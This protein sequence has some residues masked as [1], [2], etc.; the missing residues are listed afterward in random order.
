MKTKVAVLSLIIVV[1]VGAIAV[2]RPVKQTTPEQTTAQKPPEDTDDT[3]TR[4]PQSDTTAPPAA[5]P[6]AKQEE[7][8]KA[9]SPSARQLRG[10]PTSFANVEIVA[11]NLE[12]PWEI[13]FL[14]NGEMLLTERKGNLL[15]IGFDG[16]RIAIP[17]PDV[18][19]GG[20]GGLLGLT[21]HSEFA[22]N[23]LLYLYITTDRGE[24][25]TERVVNQIVR[26]RFENDTLSE[27]TVIVDHIPGALFHDGGRIA[28]GP[29]GLL[30]ATTGDARDEKLSQDNAS[31]AGKI[32]RVRDDGSIPTDNPFGTA[33]YSYGHRNSQGITWDDRGT[34]WSTE[35]GRT[36]ATKTGMDELN[37]IEK[38]KNYGWPNVEGDLT[39]PGMEP[40]VLHSGPTVTWAPAGAVYVNNSI[41]FAGLRGETLYEAK[42]TGNRSVTLVS[43]FHTEFGRIRAVALGP[44]HML[45]IST[46]NRDG[47]GK[48]RE[49]DDKIIR[50]NPAMFTSATP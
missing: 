45:Y 31:L 43:H 44:D 34:L 28:F 33:V 18:H 13:A 14:P 24:N 39:A 22:K 47:R 38:G 4:E 29:D 30:Y 25:A 10:Y 19:H 20:E 9:G 49:G 36:T 3:L 12:I 17:V 41:F 48:I 7:N 40:P 46:S 27:K 26:Y 16:T 6:Q 42:I 23:K 37:I 21:L 11:D 35:H 5:T 32:L 1:V 2:T 50:V 8:P 15:R